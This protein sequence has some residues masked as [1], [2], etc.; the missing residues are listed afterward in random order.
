MFSKNLAGVSFKFNFW[1]SSSSLANGLLISFFKTE[2][3]YLR[4]IASCLEAAIFSRSWICS[5]MWGITSWTWY[6]NNILVCNGTLP[7]F[8][9]YG[10]SSSTVDKCTC[11]FRVPLFHKSQNLS[12]VSVGKVLEPRKVNNFWCKAENARPVHR[13]SSWNFWKC[14]DLKDFWTV[15]KTFET[16]VPAL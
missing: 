14:T 13:V 9:I 11:Q 6:S 12:S 3:L 1:I 16:P 8:W 15:A 10:K 5:R 7:C 2:P 4:F